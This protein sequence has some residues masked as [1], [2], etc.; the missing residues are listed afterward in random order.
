MIMRF[1]HQLTK[2]EVGFF[3]KLILYIETSEAGYSFQTGCWEGCEAGIPGAPQISTSGIHIPAPVSFCAARPRLACSLSVHAGLL[4]TCTGERGVP[5]REAL[6]VSNLGHVYGRLGRTDEARRLFRELEQ[7][8]AQGH[9][10]PIAFA[11]FHAGLGDIDAAFDWLETAYR[12]RDGYL[13]WLA[14]TPGLDPLHSDARFANLV[15]RVGVAP[16]WLA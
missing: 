2:W 7:L 3:L 10:P 5:Q 6:S 1:F 11:V 14:G 13:F 15:R 9:A 8:R 12:I 4:W 16:L